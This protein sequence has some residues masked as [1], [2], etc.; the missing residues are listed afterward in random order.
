MLLAGEDTTAN[1]LAWMMD[2]LA[3]RP[4]VQAAMRAEAESVFGAAP[5]PPDFAST[6]SLAYIEAVA[7]E[8]MRLKPVAPLLALEPNADRVVG[9]VLVP[10]GTAVILLTAHP[11]AAEENF[12][13]AKSFRPERWIRTSEETQGA[14]NPRAFVPFGAGP[15]FCPGRHLAILEIKMVA[16]M[17]CRNFDIERAPGSSPSEE[18]FSFTMMPKSVLV[19][20]RRLPARSTPL[21][22]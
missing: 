14:H 12:S 3:D 15:R 9:D 2:L 19:R 5:R 18:V 7:L 8:A 16:A 22:A 13:D 21:V 1:T 10:K 6:E 11:A 4:D 20:L 17:L